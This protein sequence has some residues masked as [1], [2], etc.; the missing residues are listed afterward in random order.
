VLVRNALPE[1]ALDIVRIAN[2]TDAA[3]F[4]DL[5]D[6]N[7][8]FLS[9]ARQEK[10]AAERDLPTISLGDLIRFRLETEKLVTRVAEARLPTRIAGELRSCIYKSSVHSGEHVALIKGTIDPNKPTLTRVQPEFTFGD[11]FGG[12]NPPSRSQLHQALKA[13]NDHG[14]GVLVYLRR[15]ASG[16]LRQQVASWSAEYGHK[17][18]WMMREYGLGA[19]ILRDLGVKRIELLTGTPRNLSGLTTFGIEIVGQR[20]I[21]EDAEN[22]LQL[23][24]GPDANQH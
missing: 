8:E 2:F 16:Q 15:P 4:V 21:T 7:G 9:L 1:G 24:A 11:V 10:L 12:N 3:L 23:D 5:L 19:Q 17:P 22:S 14:S 6:E 20:A 18:A 13:I